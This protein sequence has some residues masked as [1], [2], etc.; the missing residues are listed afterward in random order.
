MLQQVM[1]QAKIDSLVN[2][3]WY[4]M[5]LDK[6]SSFAARPSSYALYLNVLSGKNHCLW[7]R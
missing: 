7:I 4:A 1:V 2:D 3:D 6:T 5:S